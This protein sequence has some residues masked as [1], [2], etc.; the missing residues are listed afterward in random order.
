MCN[1]RTALLSP[2]WN[3]D[4]NQE[5]FNKTREAVNFED[6]VI[7][8]GFSC[9]VKEHFLKQPVAGPMRKILF[10]IWP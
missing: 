8:R 2:F 4:N 6:L 3:D 7:M 10:Q 5:K 9:P 1:T